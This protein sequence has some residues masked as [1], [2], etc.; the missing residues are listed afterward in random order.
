MLTMGPGIHPDHP[1]S[2]AGVFL[3]VLQHGIERAGPVSSLLSPFMNAMGS[4]RIGCRRDLERI[5][6]GGSGVAGLGSAAAEVEA[7][8]GR[9]GS[10]GGLSVP[11]TWTAGT[12][13]ESAS[14]ARAV[15]PVGAS[16]GTSTSAVP[17]SASG[18]MYGG[19]PMGAGMHGR[20]EGS[21]GPPRYG[22]PVKVVQRR[23]G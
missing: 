21:D 10:L 23:S 4:G 8:A 3:T 16:G 18:G 11:A 9:A 12:S 15:T 6:F 20:G 13:S 22:K 19:S 7:T 1:A 5:K 17:A 14:T 2:A